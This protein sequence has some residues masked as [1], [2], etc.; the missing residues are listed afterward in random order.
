VSTNSIEDTCT[1]GADASPEPE[2]A[3]WDS[4][5]G[6]SHC[7]GFAP[8][9]ILSVALSITPDIAPIRDERELAARCCEAPG[10]YPTVRTTTDQG[11][12]CSAA[13]VR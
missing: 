3:A 5:H 9:A 4:R 8:P 7:P 2:W 11:N 10:R 6:L 1:G 12:A 13:A